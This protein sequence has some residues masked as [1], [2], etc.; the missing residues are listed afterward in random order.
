MSG[1]GAARFFEHG[2]GLCYIE[3][4]GKAR[5]ALRIGAKSVIKVR[6]AP[7]DVRSH[8]IET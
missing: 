4:T 7:I 3:P 8:P 6:G 1:E 2:G 5:Q